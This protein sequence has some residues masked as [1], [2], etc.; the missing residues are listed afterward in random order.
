MRYPCAPFDF[1]VQPK[2]F[3]TRQ[4]INTLDAINAG[5]LIS[6][7]PLPTS[8]F[9]ETVSGDSFDSEDCNLE[10]PPSVTQPG[11]EGDPMVG[12]DGSVY[13][14][15]GSTQTTETATWSTDSNGNGVCTTAD[16]SSAT[17]WL[18]KVSGGA[19]QLQQ[20]ASNS[21]TFSYLSYGGPTGWV[22]PPPWQVPQYSAGDVI[23]DGNGGLLA[24]WEGSARGHRNTIFD[25]ISWRRKSGS[26]NCSLVQQC[27]SIST[28]FRRSSSWRQRNGL[29]FG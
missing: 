5:S 9:S 28:V 29:L 16:N 26:R 6:Q 3:A 20:L 1:A 21:G 12:P 22:Y 7:V 19:S 8:S 17:L 4:N 25:P 13:L 15:V 11:P 23:P 2:A 10:Q 18:M 24:T 14:Q 27:L